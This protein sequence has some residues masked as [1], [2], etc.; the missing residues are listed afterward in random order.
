[1]C[2]RG[3]Q[4][5]VCVVVWKLDRLGRSLKNLVDKVHD[6]NNWGIGLRVLSGMGAEINTTKARRNRCLEYSPPSRNS[7]RS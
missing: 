4:Y 2:F 3:S 5:F 6:L 7:S 1:M